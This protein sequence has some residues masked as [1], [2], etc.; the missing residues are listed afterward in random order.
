MR[1]P[2]VKILLLALL[3]GTL[4]ACATETMRNLLPTDVIGKKNAIVIGRVISDK[5]GLGV[6]VHENDHS[7][8]SAYIWIEPA[9]KT[10]DRFERVFAMEVDA[11]YV[12]YTNVKSGA[13]YA[14]MFGAEDPYTFAPAGQITYI[15]D[16]VVNVGSFARVSF[17][18][19][20][21]NAATIGDVKKEMPW[22]FDKYPT[23]SKD[24]KKR[25]SE[26]GE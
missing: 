23:N 26:I 2:V 8:P 1:N 3:C 10:G 12:K 18:L 9:H 13:M 20:D 11:G 25:H 21:N 15:G 4:S 16:L 6:L 14:N 24:I 17:R 22:L 7:N 5:S 19:T